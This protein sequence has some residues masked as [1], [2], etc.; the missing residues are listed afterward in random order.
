MAIHVFGLTGGIATGKSTVAERW[1]QRGLPVIDADELAREVV[2]LGSAGLAAVVELMGE[3]ALLADGTL[4][5]TQVASRVF[6]DADARRAL[7]AVLHPLIQKGL[8]LRTL[9]LEKQGEPLVCY[10][11]PLLVEV[12]RADKYRPLVV[13]IASAAAQLQRALNRD[14]LTEEAL[15]A[16]I[17]S[18]LPMQQKAALADITISN[19]GTRE[20]LHREA[21]AALASVC[22]KLGID[23]ARYRLS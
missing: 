11:A 4:N 9:A 20:Q 10:G 19:D 15:R 1:R 7:E 12:G 6:A 21:D 23:K 17:A 2:A 3:G 5:R 8:T 16:R 13:V 22:R 18:Q 14:G